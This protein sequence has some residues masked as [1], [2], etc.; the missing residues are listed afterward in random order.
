MKFILG[1]KKEM[2][3]QYREDGRIVPVTVVKADRCVVTQIK[4]VEKDGYGAIQL[5]V[6]K[7]NK[8]GKSMA[9]HLAKFTEKKEKPFARLSE[10]R[11]ENASDFKVGDSIGVTMFEPGDKIAVTG[12]SK[13]KGFQGVVKRHNFKGSPASHGHKDQ[14]RMPGSI[15][16]QEPQRVFKGTRMAGRMGGDQITVKNLEVVSIDPENNLLFVKGALPGARNSVVVLIGEG[17]GKAEVNIFEKSPEGEAPPNKEEAAKEETPAE[18]EST[19]DEPAKEEA[20]EAKK[21]EPKKENEGN[22]KK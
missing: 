10:I 19:K 14:L 1:Y 6:G 4:S 18:G 9:G 15:G 12:I 3:Q 13:G 7:K 20:P 11:M 8:T 22:N 5:G 16:P 2:T 17:D 21:D